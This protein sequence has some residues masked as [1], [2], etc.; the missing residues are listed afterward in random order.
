MLTE[1]YKFVLVYAMKEYVG[2]E[3]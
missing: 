1:V 3:L 2:V